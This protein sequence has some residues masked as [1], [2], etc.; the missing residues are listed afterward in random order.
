MKADK[1][2]T[3]RQRCQQLKLLIAEDRV[4]SAIIITVAKNNPEAV[5]QAAQPMLDAAEKWERIL[6]LESGSGAALELEKLNG[7]SLAELKTQVET[8]AGFLRGLANIPLSLA[9]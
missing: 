4:A 6:S 1:K 9:K 8:M 3:M 2:S 5:K 7:K